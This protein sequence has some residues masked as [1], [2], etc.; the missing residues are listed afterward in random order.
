MERLHLTNFQSQQ[1]GKL[2]R[3]RSQV[4]AVEDGR[5]LALQNEVTQILLGN[6]GSQQTLTHRGFRRMLSHYLG[7]FVNEENDFFTTTAEELRKAK[8]FL[9]ALGLDASFIGCWKKAFDLDKSHNSDPV[10]VAETLELAPGSRNLPEKKSAPISSDGPLRKL[11]QVPQPPN[12]HHSNN[13][14]IQVATGMRGGEKQADND[15]Q[16]LAHALEVAKARE[17]L[18]K[19]PQRKISQT[20]R[21]NTTAYRWGP[22]FDFPVTEGPLMEGTLSNQH[23]NS[24]TLQTIGRF[25]RT[26]GP[27]AGV[28]LSQSSASQ[29]EPK[30]RARHDGSGLALAENTAL[31]PPANQPQPPQNLNGDFDRLC[32]VSRE[33]EGGMDS[34][35]KVATKAPQ[36]IKAVSNSHTSSGRQ[37]LGQR[38]RNEEDSTILNATLYPPRTVVETKEPPK[39]KRAYRKR[40]KVAVAP[41]SSIPW[42]SVNTSN[43][44]NGAPLPS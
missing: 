7:P 15:P 20:S 13:I 31:V 41:A 25:D 4:C 36:L 12:P 35:I 16:N 40:L 29:P 33:S 18:S 22:S 38:I 19:I 34:V 43:F 28:A 8:S 2:E 37:Q 11:F 30:L 42:P 39:K 44:Q 3:R 17:Y 27:A 32:D 10:S 9:Y 21:G 14:A 6:Y 23:R 1:I 26:L 24:P 5:I